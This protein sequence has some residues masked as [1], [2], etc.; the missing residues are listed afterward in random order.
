VEDTVLVI[1]NKNY[2]SWSLRPWLLLTHFNIAFK[3]IRIP[4]DQKTTRA[5]LK[6]LSPTLKVPVLIHNDMTVW[7]SL[8]ICEYVS[9]TFIS[10]KGWPGETAA[11]AAARS[12]SAEMHSG[13]P[14]IRARMPLNCRKAPIVLDLT[15]ELAEEMD[16]VAGIWCQ[17][18]EAYGRTGPWLFGAFTIADA[19]FAP[20]AL[21]FLTYGVKLNDICTDYVHT[22]KTHPGMVKWVEE[23]GKET[24]IIEGVDI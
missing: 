8:A 20:V 17:Y 10:G 23:A 6:P 18:R 7:D 4:L 24:E 11:R 14:C 19:M 13:F 21:R 1:G 5:A 2:S 15:P 22:L 9:E 16:R 3:E 12:V